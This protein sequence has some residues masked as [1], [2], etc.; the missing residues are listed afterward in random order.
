MS[1]SFMQQMALAGVTLQ[2]TT[3]DSPESNGMAERWNRS[4]QDK[5]RTV[6][7]AAAL[8]GYLWGEVLLAINSIRN[9]SP[10]TNLGKPP[11]EL[12]HGQ[13]PDLS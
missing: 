3:A 7:L 9:M 2:R 5:T 6:M 13:K 4:V 10:V 11:F 8:P 1:T 12:W